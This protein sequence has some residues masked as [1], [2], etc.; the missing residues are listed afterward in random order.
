MVESST[1]TRDGASARLLGNRYRLLDLLGAGGMGSV[2]RAF[3]QLTGETVA[4]KRVVGSA[5]QPV[6]TPE[7]RLALA[8]EFQALA[9]LRHPNIIAV[10]DYGFD[11]TQQPYFTMEL[12]PNARSI[13][14]AGQWLAVDGKIDRLLHLLS[15]LVYIHRRAIVHRDLKPGNVLLV[16]HEVKVL[17]FGL[18]TMAG[19]DLPSSGTL[20][21]MAPEVVRGEPAS[22]AAD[23]YAVGVIA[24]EL[25]AG[26][27]PFAHAM[28]NLPQA[29]LHEMP[30]FTFVDIEP[31]LVR[32]L[33]RL[34]AKDPAAG[35]PDASAVIAALC[36]ALDRPLPEETV[37][38]R[39][40]FLQAAPL[41]GREQE[42]AQLTAALQAAL[43]GE[44]S[45]WL[46]GGESGIGK[47]RLLQELRTQALVAGVLVL[48]G[49]ANSES[50]GAYH[51]WREALRPLVLAAQ[52]AD[53]EAA[54]LQM[55]A[56]DIATLL[57]RT[58]PAAPTL[59]PKAA[60][61]RL[62]VTLA[63]LVRREAVRQPLLFVLEDL[64][65]SDENSL[66][67]LQHLS[68]QPGPRRV[69]IVGS[70]RLDEAPELPTR[71]PL[72]TPLRL[73][74]LAADQIAHL[75]EA[76]LGSG[77]RRTHL[78]NFLQQETEGNT[79]FMVEVLRTL[80]EEVGR[81][82]RI[83]DMALPLHVFAGGMQQMVQ[84]RLQRVP[85]LY[86]PLLQLAAVAGR[87]LDL[88][89]LQ[90]LD[91]S[92]NLA[93]WLDRCANAAV[94][95]VPEGGLRWQF[96]HDK[97]REGLL[98]ELNESER[99]S[100]H[101]QIG[102]AIE[103]VYATDLAPHYADLAYHYGQA[104]QVHQERRYA[105]LAGE[106]A[107]AQFAN[108]PALTYFG[109][110][111]EL[112]PASDHAERFALLLA[113]EQVY[114]RQGARAEQQQDLVALQALAE[115]LDNRAQAMVAARQANYAEA[116]SAFPTAIQAGE[117]AMQ[118]ARQSGERASEA[119][120]ALYIGRAY[121]RMGHYPLAFQTLAT[122]VQLA[123]ASELFAL[124][125]E[126]LRIMGVVANE[127]GD[128]AQAKMHFAQAQQHFQRLGDRYGEG[129]VLSS[130]GVTTYREGDYAN[131]RMALEDALRLYQM[132]GDRRNECTVLNNLGLV[133][134]C[135]GDYVRAQQCYEQLL[136]I[137]QETG[138][139]QVEATGYG[140]LGA[141][142][143]AQGAYEQ[144]QRH[145][146]Q[147]LQLRRAI[148]DQ[149]GEV[150]SLH[151]LAL[152]HHHL[153]DNI[154]AVKY[155]RQAVQLAEA[156]EAKHDG[157]SALTFLGH[158]LTALGEWTEATVCYE[159]AI[160]LRQE[161]GEQNL[162]LEPLAGLARAAQAQGKQDKA[163]AHVATILSAL[164]QNAPEGAYEP[165]RIYL[166]CYHVLLAVQPVRAQ[167]LLQRAYHLV[168][169]R[170]EKIDDDTLRHSFL[171]NVAV[172]R[173]IVA[174]WETP[175]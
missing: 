54:V 41:I 55:V 12:L 119:F 59:E 81:L 62:L 92:M 134:D 23:L 94:L 34:L 107:A 135:R 129:R 19:Q 125:A 11:Q 21:Y 9:S 102:A 144:A 154:T 78:V 152:L 100:C 52:P 57:R 17:D 71:L 160:Q 47:S 15:A 164:A 115:T 138:N 96:A 158:A 117:S 80:A 35:Y 69:F 73:G 42:L 131:A 161:M 79:F 63:D 65:W 16:G 18:A 95:A 150:D 170:A 72:M 103:Q 171:M 22:R 64:Q 60:Q 130:L 1:Q 120:G 98:R 2:Y 91:P 58:L 173:E 49:Q 175:P 82:D 39:E 8:R 126:C 13:V 14:D 5:M 83:S 111:L 40:S 86:Q 124:E 56:P 85:A 33:E 132:I 140:N 110:A 28:Q 53:D 141:L 112:T 99:R 6:S 142:L 4:L 88:A 43:Q 121:W 36:A 147:S 133:H 127:K 156:I 157:A 104:Q 48:R 84:R 10:R 165:A 32:V 68:R 90:H 101:A 105:R 76:M 118:L 128:Y 122:A 149:Q 20:A 97:L 67:L 146:E 109:R 159:Q 139:R 108:G 87:Q 113:R 29:I 116:T 75:S 172:H 114:D 77:G 66:E 137:C 166:T 167:E 25:L 143:E 31:P 7:L 163:Q 51:L 26:W 3:D 174:L 169:E 153:D 145:F 50:G 74:R 61:A 46:V 24:Y 151:S 155:G 162:V 148:G 93:E 70:Y 106:Q 136:V 89:V 37:A 38:T 44:G 27:H 123:Q 30:D 168:W 45:A